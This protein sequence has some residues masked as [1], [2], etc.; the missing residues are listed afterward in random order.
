[1]A[2]EQQCKTCRVKFGE[3]SPERDYENWKNYGF[4]NKDAFIKHSSR[5]N[6]CPAKQQ[7]VNTIIQNI[8]HEDS[9]EEDSVIN[10]TIIL[11]IT[12]LPIDD[13]PLWPPYKKYKETVDEEDYIAEQN[14]I[15][16]L[17]K[18]HHKNN[19]LLLWHP[20]TELASTQLIEGIF[21]SNNSFMSVAAQPGSGKTAVTHNLLFKLL[22]I[23]DYEKSINPKNITFSTGMSDTDWFDQLIDSFTLKDERHLWDE[24]N[25]LEKN[26]C[27]VHRSNFHKRITYILDNLEL[28]HDHIFIFD[29]SHIAD[30]KDM[31]IDTQL[32]RLGLT[33]ERMKEYNIRII[34]ISATPDVNLSIMSRCPD[35]SLVILEPGD[36]YKGFKFFNDKHMIINFDNNLNLEQKIRSRYTTPRYHFIRARTSIEKGRFQQHIHEIVNK[37]KWTLIEDDSEHNI[38]LSFN[39]DRNEKNARDKTKEIIKTYEEPTKHTIILLKDK[40]SASKRLK[41]T[42]YTGIIAEKPSKKR[43]TSSTCNGLIPRFFMYGEEPEYSV[44]KELPLF[45]CDHTS[46]KEYIKF[47]ETFVFNG[48]DYTGNR[49]VSKKNKIVEKKNTGYSILAGEDAI[50]HDSN[51]IFKQV[52]NVI[53]INDILNNEG[54]NVQPIEIDSFHQRNG[55][56]FPKRNVPRHTYSNESDTYMTEE[57]YKT[58]KNNGGG[59]FINRSEDGQGQRFMIYPVYKELG[60]SVADVKWYVHYYK[61]TSN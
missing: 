11:N 16:R 1:M 54:I 40:Y 53:E 38:Y 43:N 57:T 34:C 45:I 41:L 55:Y 24:I 50:S 27:I 59:S 22:T 29:E 36:T 9:S 46:V 56:Y 10:E 12:E 14:A 26:H 19:G 4:N 60:C 35:H 51:I 44:K 61:N 20:S 15:K 17:E 33:H 5:N 28:I 49:I 52:N 39:N 8:S 30:S 18:L 6:K 48:K 2:P 42:K 32:N 31:T 25:R 23:I 37:N 58:Y 47:S 7:I 3:N 21:E 13:L